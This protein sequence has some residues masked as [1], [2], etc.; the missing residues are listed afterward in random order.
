MESEGRKSGEV[1]SPVFSQL[2]DLVR[3]DPL[4]TGRGV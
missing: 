1:S 3:D 2:L 4:F